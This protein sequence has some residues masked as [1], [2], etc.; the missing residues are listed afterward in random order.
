[1]KI[2]VVDDNIVS[3]R[4][5]ERILE[6][7]S[8]PTC[9]AGNGREALELLREDSDIGLVLCDV[10]MPEVGGLELVRIMKDD[11]ELC[12]LPLIIC[13]SADDEETVGEAVR[14]GCDGYLL[15]PIHGGLLLDKV[16]TLVAGRLVLRD[17]RRVIEELGLG[18]TSVVTGGA[19][20]AA[21][22]ELARAF[23]DLVQ[24]K[25]WKLEDFLRD[26]NTPPIDVTELHESASMLGAERLVSAVSR[27][28]SGEGTVARSDW[29]R[30]LQELR[31]LQKQLPDVQ[32]M[33]DAPDVPAAEQP[34]AAADAADE[35]V[36]TSADASVEASTG[37]TAGEPA[38][39]AG[40]NC[41][42][43][44]EEAEIST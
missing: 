11:P 39:G 9:S 8:Y 40:A 26:P 24:R 33:V 18:N 27:I 43:N 41:E 37:E 7:A 42:A 35:E 31:Q 4:L 1:M 3:T 28:A 16:R 10:R 44:T 14:L 32:V 20:H 21:Y 25:V 22:D 6:T 23:A 13:T 30:L 5:L 29:A 12:G 34:D 2:L 15:K 38:E 36:E 17:K 19:A